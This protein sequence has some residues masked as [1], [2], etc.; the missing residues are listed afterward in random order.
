MNCFLFFLLLHKLEIRVMVM[1]CRETVDLKS[2]KL[3]QLFD[4]KLLF[5]FSIC[6]LRS[7]IHWPPKWDVR[8]LILSST[9]R[10]PIF[11]MAVVSLL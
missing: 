7:V 10:R 9:T 3:R 1:L 5:C 4:C 8:S 2:N 11:D 6:Y